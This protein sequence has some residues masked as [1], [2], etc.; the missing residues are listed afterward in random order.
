MGVGGRGLCLLVCSVRGLSYL[1][2]QDYRKNATFKA[3]A[4][5]VS[6]IP[7]THS[8][9]FF[10]ALTL[11]EKNPKVNFKTKKTLLPFFPI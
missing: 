7:S 11:N 3:S 4:V 8:L 2:T 1:Y 9:F 5:N 6:I 10:K